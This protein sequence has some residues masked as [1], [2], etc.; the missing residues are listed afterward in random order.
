MIISRSPLRISFA[1][2]GTDLAGFYNQ[3]G[4]LVL[5]TAI[6]KYVFTTVN[7]KFGN[8]LRVSY[9]QT[10]NVSHASELS[11]A[12]IRAALKLM[13]LESGLEITTIADI[14]SSGTGLGSSSSFT[15]GLL[16]ALHAY[17]GEYASAD[18]IADEACHIEIDICG[19]PIGKQDQYAAAFG[20]LNLIRFNPDSS[21][22]VSPLV[23]KRE[24]IDEFERNLLLLYTGKTRSANT[25]LK[26]QNKNIGAFKKT[27]E[28]MLAMKK[29][30]LEMAAALQKGDMQL[31]GEILDTGWKLKRTLAKGISDPELDEIYDTAIK[32][33][34]LGGK[35]LG[36]G[37]G[38]F[39][40][41][42]APKEKHEAICHALPK[43]NP[44]P[45]KFERTGAS[46]IF[47][48]P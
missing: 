5:S 20:G 41:F 18:K 16:Q 32:S 24:V 33:G 29:Q 1:G 44:V 27:V 6:D 35:I 2:G 38:G 3:H 17:K 7:A 45:F 15:A 26:E 23:C 4:G 10:E 22:E 47:Y 12:I 39:F 37:A 8:G 36:A 40:L 13:G 11:H 31:I 34:A 28:N 46:I 9:S 30:A 48:R 43:L 42:Y 21:V 19:A 14:P 25:I